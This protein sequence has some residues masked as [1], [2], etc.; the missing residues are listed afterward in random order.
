MNPINNYSVKAIKTFRARNGHGYSC[1]L[2][3]DGKK[4]A[5]ILEEG[6][7]G[8]LRVDW[9][10]YT[11]KATVISNGYDIKEVSYQGTVEESLFHAQIMKI[12]KIASDG[13]S[14]EMTTSVNI[15][16][17][18]MVNDTLV[19]KKLMANMKKS[20]AVKCKD[21]KILTWKITPAH[22]EPTLRTHIL[23]KHPDGKIMNDLPIEESFQIYKEAGLIG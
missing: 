21:G 20:L 3:K 23:K 11:A 19:M 18:D 10:D 15:V 17:D 14:P 16:I 4:V 22:P 13:N 6:R 1:N 7:G 12:P 2:L 5:E 8:E 9:M